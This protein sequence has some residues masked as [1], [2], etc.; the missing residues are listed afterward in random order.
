MLNIHFQNRVAGS[1]WNKK[2]WETEIPRWKVV[3]VCFLT[4]QIVFPSIPV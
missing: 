2:E 1:I 3:Q 4:K